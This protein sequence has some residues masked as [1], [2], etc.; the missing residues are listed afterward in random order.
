MQPVPEGWTEKESGKFYDRHIEDL[1][2]C[3]HSVLYDPL[4]RN[5]RL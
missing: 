4:P 2:E 3:R 1:G 5:W